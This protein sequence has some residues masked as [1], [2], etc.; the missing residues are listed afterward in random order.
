MEIRPGLF[1][2]IFIILMFKKNFEFFFKNF[3]LK[4]NLKI[5]NWKLGSKIGF[6]FLIV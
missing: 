5:K 2:I 3:K 6:S 1:Y 4:K